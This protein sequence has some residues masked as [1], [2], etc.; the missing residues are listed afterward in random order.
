MS[1]SYLYLED[2]MKQLTAYS[3]IDEQINL[4][5]YQKT[6][7]REKFEQWLNLNNITEIETF[8]STQKKLYKL[9]LSKQTRKKVDMDLL[10]TL[11][12]P[13]IFDQ[14]V[15]EN[16]FQTFRI[17]PIKNKSKRPKAPKGD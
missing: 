13:E 17:Q 8:E 4:L 11:V 12:K 9:S 15:S 16:E 14:V 3:E 10:N 2:F 7:L 5:N 1:E 6:E